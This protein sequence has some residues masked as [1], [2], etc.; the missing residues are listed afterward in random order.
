MEDLKIYWLVKS[1]F[2]T[3]KGRGYKLLKGLANVYG[4]F[5]LFEC[6][7]KWRQR[8]FLSNPEN[9]FPSILIIPGVDVD[10]SG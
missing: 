7:F 9:V 4:S 10:Y 1:L 3:H 5:G 6:S 8:K 2:S